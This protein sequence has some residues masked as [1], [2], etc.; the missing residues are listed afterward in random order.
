MLKK[1]R[2][3]TFTLAL[4]LI[5]LGVVMILSLFVNLSAIITMLR[6][7]PAVLI[8]LG[9][10][11]LVNALFLK[12]DEKLRYDGMSIFLSL[13]FLFVAFIAAAAGWW[14]DYYGSLTQ[15]PEYHDFF[16]NMLKLHPNFDLVTPLPKLP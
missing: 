11:I 3:G 4:S 9:I 13:V 15:T 16:E 14:M 6:F 1:K 7:A 10:E 12:E 8:V 5:Y 2:V